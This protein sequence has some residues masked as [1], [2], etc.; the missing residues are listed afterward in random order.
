M[1]VGS[2]AAAATDEWVACYESACPCETGQYPSSLSNHVH[3]LK[4]VVEEEVAHM[5]SSLA[6]SL[7]V[8]VCMRVQY[9][10]SKSQQVQPS[11]HAE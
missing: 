9:V 5:T 4:S 2:A 7:S 6:L 8:C 1:W 10:F 11:H 3:H